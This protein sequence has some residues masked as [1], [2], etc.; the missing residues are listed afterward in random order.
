MVESNCFTLRRVSSTPLLP[1]T[2]WSEALASTLWLLI[3]GVTLCGLN[4]FR[5]AYVV[6]RGDTIADPVK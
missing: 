6:F 3:S 5:P 1:T 4:V 2:T